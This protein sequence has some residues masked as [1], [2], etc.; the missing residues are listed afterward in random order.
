MTDA[1]TLIGVILR[2]VPKLP[3]ALCRD[4]DPAVFDGDDDDDHA[5]AAKICARCPARQQCSAHAETRQH[6][7]INGI[8]AGRLHVWASHPSVATPPRDIVFEAG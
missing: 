6:N 7:T 5:A 4:V 8:Y 2:G 3:G 1:F